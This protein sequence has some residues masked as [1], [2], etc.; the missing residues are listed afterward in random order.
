MSFSNRMTRILDRFA[1]LP[2][3]LSMRAFSFAFGRVVPFV[4]TAGV[5]IESITESRVVASI[6]NRRRIRNHV[7]GVHAAAVALLAETTSGIIVGRNVHD[8]ALP[9]IKSMTLNYVK[10]NHGNFRAEASLTQEQIGEMRT[11]AQGTTAV[12]VMLSDGRGSEAVTCE[13]VW[14]WVPKKGLRRER[15]SHSG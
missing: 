6:K 4:A 14:A 9:L 1:V 11:Q 2:D 12:A 3:K 7:G 8:G 13:M 5:R 15:A 10:R